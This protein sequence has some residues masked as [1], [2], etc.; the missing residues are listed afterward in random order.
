MRKEK[1][2]IWTAG[3]QVVVINRSQK[4]M[5]NTWS[6]NR[7]EIDDTLTIGGKMSPESDW[8]LSCIRYTLLQLCNMSGG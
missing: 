5:N 4:G 3:L 6:S 2:C 7:G 8:L 1:V